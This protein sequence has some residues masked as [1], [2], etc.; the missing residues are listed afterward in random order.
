MLIRQVRIKD[1][2]TQRETFK[3][4]TVKQHTDL[5]RKVALTYSPIEIEMIKEREL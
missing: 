3:E 1:T 5:L 2:T 4:L